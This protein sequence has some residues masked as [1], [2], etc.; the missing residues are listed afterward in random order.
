MWFDFLDIFQTIELTS[1]NDTS[2]SI[3]AILISTDVPVD[4]MVLEDP[5]SE[6]RIFI[7]GLMVAAQQYCEARFELEYCWL[8]RMY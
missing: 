5:L 4:L 1:I 3:S 2:G 7:V 8:P 6:S